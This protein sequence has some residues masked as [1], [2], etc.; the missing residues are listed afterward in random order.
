MDLLNKQK[1]MTIVLFECVNRINLYESEKGNQRKETA[2]YESYIDSMY[3]QFQAINESEEIVSP[4]KVNNHKNI[5]A[6]LNKVVKFY[7]SA[8]KTVVHNL[9]ESLKTINN[10]KNKYDFDGFIQYVKDYISRI[11]NDNDFDKLDKKVIKIKASLNKPISVCGFP[12]NSFDDNDIQEIIFDKTYKY[13]IIVTKDRI[14]GYD[15]NND[16]YTLLLDFYK[17]KIY[18]D[19]L[20]FL[21]QNITNNKVKLFDLLVNTIHRNFMKVYVQPKSLGLKYT[22]NLYKDAAQR[23]A[24]ADQEKARKLAQSNEV[25]QQF[26]RMQ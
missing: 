6:Y 3:S 10:K 23:A 5:Y 20:V 9:N 4:I 26:F 12:V 11:S 1:E 24:I 7:E 15:I 19:D 17:D 2:L 18:D 14:S 13:I 25:L 21:S 16:E 8:D 22:D